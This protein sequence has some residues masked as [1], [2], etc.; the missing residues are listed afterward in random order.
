MPFPRLLLLA[1]DLLDPRE[2]RS[3][4]EYAPRNSTDRGAEGEGLSRDMG[5][6]RDSLSPLAPRAKAIGNKSF[7]ELGGRLPLGAFAQVGGEDAFAQ[8]KR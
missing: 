4:F 6:E 1:S 8:A 7:S 3:G 2:T 5:F